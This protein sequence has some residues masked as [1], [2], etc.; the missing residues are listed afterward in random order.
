VDKCARFSGY[1]D[2]GNLVGQYRWPASDLQD[3]IASGTLTILD[4]DKIGLLLTLAEAHAD[5]AAQPWRT[6]ANLDDYWERGGEE[7]L[8]ELIEDYL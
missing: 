3:H 8:W 4:P 2:D 1:T 5:D 7:R 6:S